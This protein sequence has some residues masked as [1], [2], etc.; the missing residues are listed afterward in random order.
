MCGRNCLEY[1][2]HHRR[3]ARHRRRPGGRQQRD[4]RVLRDDAGDFRAGRRAAAAGAV[5]RRAGNC[6]RRHGRPGRIAACVI[7]ANMIGRHKHLRILRDHSSHRRN[8]RAVPP[9]LRG[10]EGA[11]QERRRGGGGARRARLDS[12]HAEQPRRDARRRRHRS[13]DRVVPQR[14]VARLQ[15]R[16]GHRARAAVAVSPARGS[17]D[18]VRRRGVADGR[19]RGRRCAGGGGG[20]GGGGSARDAGADLHA[21]QGSVAVRQRH[22][23]RAGG[24]PAAHHSRRGR[25]DRE[26]RRAAGVDSRTTSRWSAIRRTAIRACRAGARSRRRR[27]SRSSGTSKTF[28]RTGAPGA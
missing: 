26:V 3:L 15:D 10:A 28:R 22:A 11:G 19:V 12:R 9:L 20:E 14:P 23:H 4:D 18:R 21:G 1:L 6:T 24:S 5:R 13:R 16:R 27:C 17:A 8:L 2:I 25:R 7:V